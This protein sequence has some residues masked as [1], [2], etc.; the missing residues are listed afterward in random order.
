MELCTY[1]L[2]AA[3]LLDNFRRTALEKASH[4]CNFVC[5]EN[6]KPSGKITSILEVMNGKEDKA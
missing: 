6:K 3:V 1:K 4:D 2:E 5:D